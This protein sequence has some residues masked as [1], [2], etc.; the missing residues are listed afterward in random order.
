MSLRKLLLGLVLWWCPASAHSECP[1]TR[2]DARIMLLGD[3]YAQL[4]E[5]KE[6]ASSVGV[7]LAYESGSAEGAIL[8]KNGTL[9]SLKDDGRAF[10]RSV[11][12]PD[13]A[14]VVF[15]AS[16]RGYWICPLLNL[17]GTGASLGLAGFAHA[18]SLKWEL[19]DLGERDVD[20]YAAGFGVPLRLLNTTFGGNTLG[21]TLT[22]SATLRG[23]AG[24]A[25]SDK[26]FRLA[27]LGTVEKRAVGAQ[28][29]A[30]LR[31]NDVFA[32]ATWT[33]L[34]G[35]D[36]KIPGLTG[37]RLVVAIRFRGAIDLGKVAAASPA[38][39]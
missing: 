7:G 6:T 30:E 18:G 36:G 16:I 20:V 27:A 38:A 15:S 26:E 9:S 11:L 25:G 31:I 5:G 21:V 4:V 32:V 24:D 28:L 17:W 23:Y 12:T 37:G 2:T 39:K 8:M 1:Q 33:M 22:P 10:G 14:N 3:G 29:E 19:A 13:S 35:E 34:A